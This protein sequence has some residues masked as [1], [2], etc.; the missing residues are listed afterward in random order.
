MIHNII[1]VNYNGREF[2]RKALASLK[3]AVKAK[4]FNI[5]IVDN[6][7]DYEDQTYLF[8]A[9][10][11]YNI[12]KMFGYTPE[13]VDYFV[14]GTVKFN[15]PAMRFG[16]D[17]ENDKTEYTKEVELQA[18]CF[19]P[20][21]G[22]LNVVSLDK[23][24]RY[25]TGVNVGISFARNFL[26]SDGDYILMGSDIE[27]FRG[28]LDELNR[29]AYMHESI[30]IVAAKQLSKLNDGSY[31]VRFGGT[32]NEVGHEHITGREIESG[33]WNQ[34][35]EYEWVTFSLVYV[36]AAFIDSVGLMDT[37]FSVYCGDRDLCN[38]GRQKGWACVYTP[39]ARAIH[40]EGRTVQ[41]LKRTLPK[42]Q[43]D[44]EQ[45][46]EMGYFH[47]KWHGQPRPFPLVPKE[48]IEELN[49]N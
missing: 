1:I 45:G 9:K 11:E 20:K 43:W 17:W 12:W 14:D 23:N 37:T 33:T 2:I 28:A 10:S 32:T 46:D 7:S 4:S 15:H 49:G 44:K 8:D 27:L 35:G 39:N 40:H 38:R 36:K 18:K 48:V 42:E 16:E 25:E 26:K 47:R 21:D 41:L 5:V 19:S 6:G 3:F 29:V 24:Y 22:F 34:Y 13:E 30:G 31:F